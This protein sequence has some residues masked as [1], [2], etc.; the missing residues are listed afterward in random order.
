V[1]DGGF[2]WLRKPYM[3]AELAAAVRV[4]LDGAQGISVK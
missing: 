4:E 2:H 1:K 3:K